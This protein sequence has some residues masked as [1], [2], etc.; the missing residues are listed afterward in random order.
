VMDYKKELKEK[1]EF[2]K[3]PPLYTIPLYAIEDLYLIL[4]CM[5]IKYSGGMMNLVSFAEKIIKP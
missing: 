1:L 4:L 2:I 3:N 5:G